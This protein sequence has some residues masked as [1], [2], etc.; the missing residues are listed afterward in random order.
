VDDWWIERLDRSHERAE[1]SCGNAALDDFLRT[2]VSQYERRNLGSTYVVVLQ[3][4]KR[5]R[6]YYTL[7][8]S[9][10][11]LQNCPPA[12][13]RKLPRHPVPVVLL[14]RLAVDRDVQG[15]GLGKLLLSDAL[16]RCMTLADSLGIHAVEVSAINQKAKHF[17]LKYGFLPLQDNDFHLLMPIATIQKGLKF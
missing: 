13:S 10:V 2:R 8:A 3:G 17:Y 12:I 6:G 16:K 9:S 14:A 4:T 7:A 11:P 1:F 5:T 15:H